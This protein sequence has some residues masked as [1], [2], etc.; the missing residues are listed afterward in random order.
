M[1]A[2]HPQWKDLPDS[3]G[4]W[5]LERES[6]LAAML[7]AKYAILDIKQ[8]SLDRPTSRKYCVR[9]YGPIPTEA[10]AAQIIHTAEPIQFSQHDR[11]QLQIDQLIRD[12]KELNQ[13]SLQSDFAYSA[14]ISSLEERITQEKEARNL[15][16][17]QHK[18][19]IDLL[20]KEI[21]KLQEEL[22]DTIPTDFDLRVTTLEKTTNSLLRNIEQEKQTRIANDRAQVEFA[23]TLATL[24]DLHAKD[25]A[26]LT[27]YPNE[28]DKKILANAG[29]IARIIR[30]LER[31]PREQ[32]TPDITE[33]TATAWNTN[34]E[35]MLRQINAELNR[36]PTG[37]VKPEDIW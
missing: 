15:L 19:Q 7:G 3:P 2:Q 18:E 27:A 37:E 25:L 31:L 6:E 23:A 21:D 13:K 5:V 8:C 22:D 32:P 29:D 24:L 26:E 11:Q 4:V 10:P 9:A 30:H 12:V 16:E 14:A 33:P 17:T 28:A 1:N 35:K 20:R 34:P 36:P